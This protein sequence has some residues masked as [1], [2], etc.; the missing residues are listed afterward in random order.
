MLGKACFSCATNTLQQDSVLAWQEIGEGF[1]RADDTALKK[2]K[3]FRARRGGQAAPAACAETAPAA[4]AAAT[5]SSNPFA[6]ISL[7]P[8][9]AGNPFAGIFLAA[10]AAPKVCCATISQCAAR[11]SHQCCTTSDLCSTQCLALLPQHARGTQLLRS[12]SHVLLCPWLKRPELSAFPASQAF[13]HA[14]PCRRQKPL[15]P[16]AVQSLQREF[17][18]RQCQPQRQ[19]LPSLQQRRERQGRQKRQLSQRR[20][21]PS[22]SP[23][24]MQRRLQAPAAMQVRSAFAQRALC[25]AYRHW[26]GLLKGLHPTWVTCGQIRLHTVLAGACFLGCSQRHLVLHRGVRSPL[27]QRLCVF[28]C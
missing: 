1:T 11:L 20:Q 22:K 12:S 15:G 2:R 21:C 24:R 16:R 5:A 10:P 9:A 19:L 14:N 4:G 18:H 3:I 25:S 8:A 13:Q 7:T 26:S 17:Q 28:C 6:G 23:L 27:W